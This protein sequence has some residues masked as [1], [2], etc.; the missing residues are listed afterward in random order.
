MKKIRGDKPIWVIIHTYIEISQGNSLCS[1]LYLKLKCHVFI[2][3]FLF[4][5]LYN[6]RRGG[7]NESCPGGRAGTNGGGCWGRG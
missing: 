2:L 7:Q 3:S 5:L 6:Q 4:F 1:Y